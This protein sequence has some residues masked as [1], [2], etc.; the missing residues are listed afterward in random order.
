MTTEEATGLIAD[1]I[2]AL[3]L[4]ADAAFVPDLTVPITRPPRSRQFHVGKYI[5][6]AELTELRPTGK[7]VFLGPPPPDALL[8]LKST[9]L[10]AALVLATQTSYQPRRLLALLRQF[11]AV[12]DWSRARVEGR[13]REAANIER[14]Q[15]RAATIID[16]ELVGRALRK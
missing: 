5:T 4:A 7:P 9:S 8:M 3:S 13:K 16:A 14:S 2:L 10:S 15:Q 6:S 1:R 11:D 12:I